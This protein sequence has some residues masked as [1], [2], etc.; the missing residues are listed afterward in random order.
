MTR[1]LEI[2]RYNSY[3]ITMPQFEYDSKKSKNNK[4]HHGVDFEEAQEL[5]VNTHV[6]I[7][8]KNVTGENRS[9][10]L[11]KIKGKH[12]MAIF[13]ERDESIRIISCHRADRRW[14]KEY[15]NYIK[16]KE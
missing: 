11:G 15:E 10:I 3:T 9:A 14:Q 2:Y 8:A 6:I 16:P 13:T 5:W 7:P 1:D 4:Q 12:Y